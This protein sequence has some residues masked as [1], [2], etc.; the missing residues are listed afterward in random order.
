[1]FDE[2]VVQPRADTREISRVGGE[3]LDC[4]NGSEH[5]HVHDNRV[6]PETA[7]MHLM[8][9]FDSGDA[10]EH[11]LGLKDLQSRVRRGATQ[12]ISHIRMTV[13][14][15]TGSILAVKSSIDLTTAHRYGKGEKTP[16]QSLRYAH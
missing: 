7:K 12:W 5:P 2:K 11:R 4:S 10:V 8:D 16:G 13:E 3:K 6:F 1:M 14:E 9:A 15:R